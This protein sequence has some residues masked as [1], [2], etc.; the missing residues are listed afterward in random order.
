MID[1]EVD[2]LLIIVGALIGWIIGGILF[3]RP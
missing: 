3:E 1:T 2:I